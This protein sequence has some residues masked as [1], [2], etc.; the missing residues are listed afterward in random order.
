[1]GAKRFFF[2]DVLTDCPQRDESLG[3]A[4]DA[5]VF[6][7]T[8]AFNFDVVAFYTKWAKD[9]AADQLPNG[10]ITNMVPDVKGNGGSMAWFDVAIVI[11]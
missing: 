11:P 10:N 9:I 8:A 6:S 7:M 4:G 3:W 5:Q 1:V 2:L